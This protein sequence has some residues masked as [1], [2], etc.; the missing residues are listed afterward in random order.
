M[1]EERASKGKPVT[2]RDIAAAD[3]VAGRKTTTDERTLMVPALARMRASLMALRTTPFATGDP[4]TRFD[5]ALPGT[6]LPSGDNLAAF[7][8]GTPPEYD[9]DPESLAFLTAAVTVA[10]S[11]NTCSAYGLAP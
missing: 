9:G 10:S 3:R 11:S 5:P 7:S 2:T 8:A 1:S 4:A 6:S